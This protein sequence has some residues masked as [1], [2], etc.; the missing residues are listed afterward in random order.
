MVTTCLDI[1]WLQSSQQQQQI[2]AWEAII[3][4]FLLHSPIGNS[5]SALQ[6]WFRDHAGVSDGECKQ[7]IIYKLNHI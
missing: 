1:I 3:I 2:Q 5:L 6:V 7:A 4:Y